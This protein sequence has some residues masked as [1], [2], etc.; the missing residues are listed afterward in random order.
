MI[1]RIS[2]VLLASLFTHNVVQAQTNNVKL[3]VDAGQQIATVTKFFNGSNIEGYLEYFQFCED[4][5]AEPMPILAAGVPCQNSHGGQQG[6]IP[7]SEMGDYIQEIFDL[8][9][10]ANGDVNTKWGKIRAESGQTKPFNLKYIGIGNEDQITDVFEERFEM[11]FNAIKEK[12][13]EI[14]VIGTTDPFSE[15]TDYVEGWKV[16]DRLNVPIVDEHYYQ[17]PGWF[18]HNQDYYDRYDRSKSKVYLG[19]YAAHLPGRPNNLETALAEALY[20]TSVERNG[21]IVMMTSYAPLLAKEGYT[22]WNPSLI[23]FNNTEVKPTVGYQVQKLYG[24]NVG[25]EYLQNIVKIDSSSED[26]RKRIA[27]STVKD[28]NTGDLIIKMV[29]LLPVSVKPELSIN[30]VDLGDRTIVK[31]VLT[32]N[33]VDKTLKPIESITTFHNILKE[34]LPPSSFTVYRI[35]TKLKNW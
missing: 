13:P 21:D 5:G 26:V 7:M 33:P 9:E 15:G 3:K 1:K 12:Y 34:E 25:N 2:I 28:S 10:W 35:Q 14:V 29:N 6:G 23:Y 32:G 11:I 16:A 22:Q 20:L 8:I 30:G 18:I 31:N 17:Q 27:I 24:H 4:I 19:E